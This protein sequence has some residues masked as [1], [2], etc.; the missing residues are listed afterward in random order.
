VQQPAKPVMPS[1]TESRF[2]ERFR[3]DWWATVYVRAALTRF[4]ADVIHI[5]GPSDVERLGVRLRRPCG[6]R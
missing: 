6:Y 3:L 1:H 2:T 5:T 4:A